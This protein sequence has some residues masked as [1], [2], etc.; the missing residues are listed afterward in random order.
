MDVFLENF[1]RCVEFWCFHSFLQW[2]RQMRISKLR[3]I[4]DTMQNNNA[5]SLQSCYYKWRFGGGAQQDVILAAQRWPPWLKLASKKISVISFIFWVVKANE[6]SNV[7]CRMNSGH[8]CHSCKFKNGLGSSE[9]AGVLWQTPRH[10]DGKFSSDHISRGSEHII[11]CKK[12]T[13]SIF[14]WLFPVL[15]KNWIIVRPS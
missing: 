1:R 11:N 13:F 7:C 5:G 2:V 8:L 3:W 4:R 6:T 10:I 15:T 9:T 12:K 14:I